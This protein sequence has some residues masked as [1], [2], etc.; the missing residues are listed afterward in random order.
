MSELWTIEQLPDQV[1]ELLS[2]NYDGQSNGRIRELPNRRTIRWYTTI[3]LVDRPVTT[4]GRTAYYGQRHLLQIVAVKK[5]QAAGRSLAEVQELLLGATDAKLIEL[6]GLSVDR[7]RPEVEVRPTGQ[8]W[9][10]HANGRPTVSSPVAED[11]ATH[12]DSVARLVHGVRL[13][14]SV[15]VVLEAAERVPDADD[16]AAIQEAAAPLLELLGRIGLAPTTGG[17]DR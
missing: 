10:G 1:A 16:V 7:V 6:A 14:D 3:G 5:L 2:E 4:R 8:F 9:K 12:G 15:T 13:S 11:T 17:E